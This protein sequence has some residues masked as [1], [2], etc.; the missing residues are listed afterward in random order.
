MNKIIW[1]FCGHT[2]EARPPYITPKTGFYYMSPTDFDDCEML[3]IVHPRRAN[4]EFHMDIRIT[5]R[6]FLSAGQRYDGLT[7][8]QV[9]YY[10]LR[11]QQFRSSW[12]AHL[13][14]PTERSREI[15]E[16]SEV[17][18]KASEAPFNTIISPE[19]QTRMY[20]SMTAQAWLPEVL[21]ECH[22]YIMHKNYK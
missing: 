11:G 2:N 1:E 12:N 3:A 15:V 5:D 13:H 6:M 7:Y 10:M 9:Q 14:V 8:M 17:D 21:D 18:K 4:S 20:K 16:A 22:K 19:T